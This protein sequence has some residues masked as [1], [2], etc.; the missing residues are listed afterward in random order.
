MSNPAN[1][2]WSKPT[3]ITGSGISFGHE[4]VPMDHRR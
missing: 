3:L 2:T 4:H 1:V